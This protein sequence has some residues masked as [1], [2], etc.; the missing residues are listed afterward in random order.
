LS[1]QVRVSTV[2]SLTA[3]RGCRIEEAKKVGVP[4]TVYA[5]DR[6][7][8]A[9]V[10]DR[11]S[12]ESFSGTFTNGEALEPFWTV[13]VFLPGNVNFANGHFYDVDINL[14]RLESA[15][16][17]CTPTAYGVYLEYLLNIT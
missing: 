9:V 3:I 16:G 11:S 12:D 4:L 8:P 6:S 5:V 14:V 15:V 1:T 17:V 13:D 2:P 7:A 10:S